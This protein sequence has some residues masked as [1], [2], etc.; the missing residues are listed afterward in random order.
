LPSSDNITG[1]VWHV[2]ADGGEYAWNG[3]EWEPLGMIVDLSGY[4]QLS[5][6]N[7]TGPVNFGDSVTADDVTTGALVV[8]GNASFTN[9]IQAN[10]IN[11]VEVGSN[12]KFT[13]TTYTTT[14]SAKTN[15]TISDHTTTSVGSAS[16]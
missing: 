4:A 2:T 6:A 10:T 14:Q 15:I 7:F 11:G 16:G 12:P 5:G 13:D 1:D 3:S 9:N 8:T